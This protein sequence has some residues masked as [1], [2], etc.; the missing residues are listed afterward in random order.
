MPE[1]E[2]LPQGLCPSM[3]C[4]CDMEPLDQE[5]G[6]SRKEEAAELTLCSL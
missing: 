2:F 4:I 3:L 5:N 1:G 6:L